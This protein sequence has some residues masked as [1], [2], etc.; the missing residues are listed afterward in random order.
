MFDLGRLGVPGQNRDRQLAPIAAVLL[1]A[2]ATLALA[3]CGGDEATLA[4]FAGGWQAH[5]RSLK[6]T[7]T[8]NADEWFALGL[9]HFVVEL[10]FRLTR[11]KGTPH[12]ATA[13][14]TVTAVRIGDRSAYTAAHPA[15]RV[16]DSFRIR[17]RDGV[18]TEPLTGA[19]YCGPGVDWPD[20]GC[21]A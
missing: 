16:N 10:R 13:T 1:S 2:M 17:L 5:G 4:S 7:R 8:G 11:P 20:T 15:P 18:I 12:D 9:G 21:G 19:N 3:G 6:I 14:A